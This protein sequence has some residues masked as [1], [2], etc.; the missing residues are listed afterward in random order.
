MNSPDE[1]IFQF[2]PCPIAS[3]PP[4]RD[5]SKP[6]ILMCHGSIVERHGHDL[7]V[8][9]VEK[10]RTTIPL[11]QLRIYGRR[12][13]F[14]DQVMASVR[15]K[16][17]DGAIRYCGACSQKAIVAA[18][19][20]CDLGIIPNRRAIFTELNTPTR[21]FEYLACGVPVI[22]PRAAGILDYFSESAMLYFE[23]GDAD[24]L[25]RQIE[26]AY[27]HPREVQGFVHRGQEVYRSYQWREE[28]ARLIR[29]TSGLLAA[30]DR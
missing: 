6:F 3:D 1:S 8:A 29:M 17:L 18:I 2:R 13:A 30:R 25:A 24:D 21:I 4:P 10:V 12:T 19:G 27:S 23:L 14:L 11:I 26:F 20:E 16:Q 15:E 22:S 7:A 5:A 9:A 28:R